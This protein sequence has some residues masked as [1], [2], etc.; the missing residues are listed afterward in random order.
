MERRVFSLHSITS[1]AALSSQYLYI[2]SLLSQAK[3]SGSY[4][5]ASLNTATSSSGQDVGFSTVHLSTKHV[6]VSGSQGILIV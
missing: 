4:N 5:M 6:L 1:Q 2:H 3:F